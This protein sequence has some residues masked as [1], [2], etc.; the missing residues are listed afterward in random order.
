MRNFQGVLIK[1]GLGLLGLSCLAVLLTAA[2][3]AAPAAKAAAP[4]T[5]VQPKVVPRGESI[6]IVGRNWPRRSVVVLGIGPPQSESFPI[7][8]VR[9][10]NRGRFVKRVTLRGTPGLYIVTSCPVR[11]RAAQ[12]TR[13]RIVA[14]AGGATT[15]LHSDLP[16]AGYRERPASVGFTAETTPPGFRAVR[17]FGLKWRG[18]GDGQATARGRARVCKAGDCRTSPARVVATRRVRYESQEWFYARLQIR[19]ERVSAARQRLSICS[20]PP[21]CGGPLTPP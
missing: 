3:P 17:L 11:C 1:A 10:D 9:T 16:R 2:T 5:T 8:R 18:W 14:A 20:F 4:I 13:V 19:V 12:R 6:R 7:G 15:L 21:L